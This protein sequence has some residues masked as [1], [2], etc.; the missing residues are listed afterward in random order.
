MHVISYNWIGP[1]SVEIFKLKC[2]IGEHVVNMWTTLQQ[3]LI[4]FAKMLR[5]LCSVSTQ[6]YWDSLDT[7]NIRL[8]K[9]EIVDWEEWL[10][11]L[12][13]HVCGNGIVMA[14]AVFIN[15]EEDNSST[16]IILPNVHLY[17]IV[18]YFSISEYSPKELLKSDKYV[19]KSKLLND[20]SIDHT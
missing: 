3:Q 16:L 20:D 1:C 2:N 7:F 19:S 5:H 12:F 9:T 15:P 10:A 11:P 17:Q 14:T 13:P 6:S 8:K 4:S 18:L